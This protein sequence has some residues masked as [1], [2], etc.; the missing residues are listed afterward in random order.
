M[1]PIG[2]QIV[3]ATR[4]AIV[5]ALISCSGESS[6]LDDVPVGTLSMQLAT[7]I[8]GIRYRLTRDSFFLTGPERRELS[9]NG[10]GSLVFAILPAGDYEMEL[11]EGWSLERQAESGFE[12]V[13]AELA[14]PNPRAF[15]IVSNQT[16]IVAWLFRTDGVPL[17]L[18]PGL[19]QGVLDVIDSSNPG[20]VSPDGGFLPGNIEESGNDDS[21]TFP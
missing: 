2:N 7:Q 5:G 8:N 1:R 15:Q 18:A 6:V 4:L 17:S 10:D 19:V 12:P 20:T 13:E 21:G 14:S 16:T 9:H 11:L 3:R